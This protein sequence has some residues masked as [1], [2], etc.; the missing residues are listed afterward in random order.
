MGNAWFTEPGTEGEVTVEW[1]EDSWYLTDVD[2]DTEIECPLP[3]EIA[4]EP[5]ESPKQLDVTVSKFMAATGDGPSYLFFE[6]IE[7]NR[8]QANTQTDTDQSEQSIT[9]SKTIRKTCS[10]AA[11]GSSDRDDLERIA[12]EKIGNEEFTVG[13]EN[14]ESVVGAAKKRARNQGRD[15]AIDPKLQGGDSDDE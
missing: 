2:V 7:E 3:D 13:Q 14:R 9:S 1:R 10:D 5:T 12:R 11:K 4:P 15:P 6:Q 8:S